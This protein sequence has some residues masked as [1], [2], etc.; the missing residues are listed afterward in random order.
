MDEIIKFEN[1]SISMRDNE[2]YATRNQIT[3]LYDAPR[4]T[5]DDNIKA[6][7]SDGLIIGRI[8]A[9]SSEK[10]K[11]KYDTEVYDL[12]EIISIGF[13]LRSDKAIKFQKWA[14]DII[15]KELTELNQ[16]FRMQQAQLDW[17]WDKEDQK[18]LYGVK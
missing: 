15:K 5:L 6:L 18:D 4:K 16:K 12:D 8:V 14:R 3:E 17:F 10:A 9:I 2:V 7:K 13:R 11:R 1:T